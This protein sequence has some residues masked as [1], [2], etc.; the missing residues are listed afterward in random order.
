LYY[1]CQVMQQC[2]QSPK[3]N[4]NMSLTNK[5]SSKKPYHRVVN[6]SYFNKWFHAY[7]VVAHFIKINPIFSSFLKSKAGQVL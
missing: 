2:K 5:N 7:Q 3:P 1:D 4:L 6:A